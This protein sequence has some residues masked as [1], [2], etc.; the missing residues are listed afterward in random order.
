MIRVEKLYKHYDDGL[1]K[2]LNGISFDVSKGE[3][4]AIMGPS[5]CGKSTLLNLIGALDVPTSGE[6]IIDGKLLKDIGSL[7]KYRSKQVGFVFQFHNLIP[8]ITLA[9]NVE[10]PTLAISGMHSIDRKEKALKLLSEVG[11]EDRAE[12]LPTK[13]SGGER[14]RAAVARALINSPKILLADEPTGNVDSETA[15]F[16]MSI[17]LK[18]CRKDNMTMLIVSHNR[19]IAKQAD[20]ILFMRDGCFIG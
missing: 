7:A 8:N 4:C 15:E 3:T 20:R 16:I 11:L 10:L 9:E 18:R 6:I 5:G 12:F 2:A 17:I 1:V 13:I 19:D 14:Q